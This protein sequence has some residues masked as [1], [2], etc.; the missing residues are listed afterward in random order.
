[1][2]NE[3]YKIG[4]TSPV[5]AFLSVPGAEVIIRVPEEKP[6]PVETLI[7]ILSR[8]AATEPGGGK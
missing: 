8:V 5:D 3:P 7:A 4:N 1:M 2:L 6:V